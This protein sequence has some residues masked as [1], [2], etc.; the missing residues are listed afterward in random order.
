MATITAVAAWGRTSVPGLPAVQS[1]SLTVTTAAGTVFGRTTGPV[2]QW[3]GIPYVAPPVGALRWQPPQPVEPWK[4][5]RSAM[6]YGNRC[7]QLADANGP[8]VNA[9]NCLTADV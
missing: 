5:V 4:G 9:E 2:D 7:G 8:R 3:L 1:Q 6:T